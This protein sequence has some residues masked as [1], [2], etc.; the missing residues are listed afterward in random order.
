MD[1]KRI[2]MNYTVPPSSEDIE[3]LTSF[4]W[5]NLPDE[6]MGRCND[7]AVAVE[8][9]ADDVTLDDLEVD[10][11]FELLALY[12]GGK[13]IAPGIER[14]VASENDVLVLYR[15]P[16]LDMWCES[17]DDLQ[18]LIRQVIVEE[19]GRYFEFSEEDIEEMV[20]QGRYT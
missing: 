14:K 18:G 5:E 7:L 8:E 10:D 20:E 15:R 13:E 19:L 9:L 1:C 3:D 2:I 17:Q 16:L 11:S 4:L 12:K 6:L